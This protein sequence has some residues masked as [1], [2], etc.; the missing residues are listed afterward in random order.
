MNTPALLVAAALGLAPHAALA[1]AG[2]EG[3]PHSHWYLE[4]S[5]SWYAGA[6]LGQGSFGGSTPAQNLDDGSF[7][8]ASADDSDFGYRVFGGLRFLDLGRT[9]WAIEFGY[10]DGGEQ[11]LRATSDGTSGSWNAG[12]VAADVS[13]G[14]FDLALVGAFR[15]GERWLAQGRAGMVKWESDSRIAG[16]SQAFG[17]LEL[18]DQDDGSDLVLGAGIGYAWQ[19]WRLVLEYTRFD[20]SANRFFTADE[21]LATLG[22]SAAFTFGH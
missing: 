17:P 21:R 3:H 5:A 22:L 9:Q 12:P 14:G 15:I 4:T 19:T 18:T 7:V 10:L 8:A 13:V 16:D 6:S 11:N 20:F 1:D 2:G